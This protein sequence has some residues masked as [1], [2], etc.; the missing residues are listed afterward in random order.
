MKRFS[1]A[2]EAVDLAQL[3]AALQHPGSGGFCAFEGWV[4]D[5]NDG[6]EVS[7]L[8]YEAYAELAIIEGERIIEEAVARYGVIA[9][10]CVHRTGDLQIGEL[11]VWI[12]V[13]SAHR[14]EAFRACRYVID[15][16]KH[17]LPIWK[18]EHY[19]TGDTAWV[20][21]SHTERAHE[22]DPPLGHAHARGHD[23]ELPHRQAHQHPL[24]HHDH[25]HTAAV[26]LG[27]EAQVAT[28]FTPDYSRQTRLREMGEAGQARLAAAR[29]LV[30]GAG[31]LGCPVLSYLAG[32]GVGTLGIVD[33]DRLDASNLHRQT[34][35]DA[36]DVGQRKVDLAARRIAA[37]NP[38]VVV[39]T[40]GEP[41]HAGNIAEVF[42]RYDLVVECTDDLGSRYLSNDAAVFTGTPL[43]LASV[44]Q[45]EGQ[46]QVVSAQPDAP[47][48]RCL[49]PQPPAPGVAGSCV[50]S[51]VLG[52]VPGV[53]GALQATE[54]LK[55]LLGLPRPADHVLL[56]IN[57]LDY[58]TQ[59]LPIDPAQGC[60]LHGGCVELARAALAQ[61]QDTRD[62]E[63]AFDHLDAAVAAGYALVDVREPD[64]IAA[65]P[66]HVPSRQ[67]LSTQIAARAAEL[68]EGR[69]LLVCATGKRSGHAARTL[70]GQG[71]RQVHSLSGGLAALQPARDRVPG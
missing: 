51:G 19:L 33:S 32:A 35:Y 37:L 47:C 67:L 65:Q 62:V 58:S 16:I 22:H 9:A 66:L 34:M 38:S 21:C 71:M 20:A 57:L 25:Q 42:A 3:H 24:L 55:L 7:G 59:R 31:G 13:S 8:E 10:H 29:V 2:G 48:L 36:R 14:D 1:L 27:R 46:L 45:Y 23:H 44:Y 43:I 63:L 64:E 60:A 40:Y 18:K 39:Q 4:R 17:R 6:R 68:A 28:T 53:L 70:R 26:S 49:W 12:G 30:I 11:A 54:A 15:E 61:A 41:L 50:E 69:V 5:S 52:P 56:L